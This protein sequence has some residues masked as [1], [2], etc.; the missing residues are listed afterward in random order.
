MPTKK[1][2]PA[3]KP[4]VRKTS[5]IKKPV[6]LNPQEAADFIADVVNSQVQEAFEKSI[7]PVLLEANGCIV[8]L[9][10][11]LA[12][13]SIAAHGWVKIPHD[14]Q[15][16]G[17]AWS[18][19]L[20]DVIHLRG[21]YAEALSRIQDLSQRL[22]TANSSV[23]DL[24]SQLSFVTG[25]LTAADEKIDILTED[26]VLDWVD[27]SFPHYVD[28]T[29][30]GPVVIDE[31]SVTIEGAGPV[32]LM[33]AV[34]PDGEVIS[35]RFDSNKVWHLDPVPE[36]RRVRLTLACQRLLGVI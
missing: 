26:D 22:E 20:E 9:E 10:A 14:L 7:E 19:A 27:C 32:Y 17:Y 33:E 5:K 16:G 13:C 11:Q 2:A 25:E 29:K 6:V 24:V 35:A 23:A 30:K 3:K 1:K 28:S 4:A 21:Q 36:D 15:K 31:C 34:L 12:G 18:Q 8:Q